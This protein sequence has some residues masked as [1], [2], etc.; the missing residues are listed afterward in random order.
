MNRSTNYLSLQ[1]GLY[2]LCGRRIAGDAEFLAATGRTPVPVDD[3]LFDEYRLFQLKRSLRLVNEKSR[4]YKRLFEKNGVDPG[5]LRSMDELAKLPFTLPADLSGN[6]Y[7][8]LCGSQGDVEK[9]VTFYSSG[10]TG[11]KKRIFFSMADIQKILDFLPRGMNTVIGREAC[12]AQIFLQNSM[13]RG[14][15]GIL[16]QSLE[17][18]GMRAWTSELDED[19]EEI[20]RKTVEN[21]VNVWFG[22]AISILR[23]TRLLERRVDLASLGMQCVFVTMTNIPA[24]MRQYLARAWNCRVSTHYGLT[25][26]GWGLAVDCD[27]CPGYHYNELDNY[28]EIVDPDTGAPLPEGQAG[29]VVLTTLSRGCMPLIRYRTGDIST[30]RESV[31]GSHLKLLGHIQ[32]RREGAYILEGRELYPALFD[33]PLFAVPELLDYRLHVLD[34]RLHIEA[35]TLEQSAAVAER[36]I[37]GLAG[38]PALSGLARPSVTLLPVGALRPFCFEKKRILADGQTDG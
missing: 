24:S 8:F 11:M 22:E 16:A 37:E 25:E 5:A 3:A 14:I 38:V 10:S 35:E 20:L 36:I 30:L 34:G 26:S 29:E 33:E 17:A 32:R 13:G 28:I 27:V 21:R 1:Q 7:N 9:P 18:F 2:E 15:G 4:F 31:C 19:V 23:A 12:R 6:S